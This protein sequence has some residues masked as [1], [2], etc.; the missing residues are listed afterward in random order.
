MGAQLN[1]VEILQKLGA[2]A[3]EKQ[4]NPKE[5]KNYY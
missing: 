2:W 5:L 1:Q 4:R 3:E